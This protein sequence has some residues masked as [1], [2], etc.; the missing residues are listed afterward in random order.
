MVKGTNTEG[1]EDGIVERKEVE[2]NGIID[3]GEFFCKR[4]KGG[5]I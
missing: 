3:K 5:N 2:K 1:E 4:E